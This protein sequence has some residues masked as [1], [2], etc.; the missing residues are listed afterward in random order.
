MEVHAGNDQF[1]RVEQG[2]GLC[3]IDD[4]QYELSADDIVVIPAG[5]RHNIINTDNM[6]S[7][8]M[9]TIYAPPHHK[10]GIVQQ[11]R[12]EAEASMEAFDGVTSE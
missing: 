10:D 3:I 9:Y 7:L 1:F 4:K 12:K 8:K 5:A 2:H 6:T 11:T